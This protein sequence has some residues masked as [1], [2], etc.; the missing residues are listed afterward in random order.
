MKQFQVQ[1]F[2]NIVDSGPV[3]V[4]DDVTCL[5]GMNEAGKSAILTALARLN[6]ARPDVFKLQEDYPRWLKAADTR[7][8]VIEEVEPIRATF[9]VEPKERSAVEATFGEGVL[10]AGGG[11][12][13]FT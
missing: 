7:A 12:S 11:T 2:R 5:V 8:G 1:K 4:Q 3:N 6:P 9:Q 10:A 13:V